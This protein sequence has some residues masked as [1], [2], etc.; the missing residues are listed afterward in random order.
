MKTGIDLLALACMY[1]AGKLNRSI[2]R[3][4]IS[5]GFVSGG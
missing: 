2:F 3:S 5:F 1:F 4:K